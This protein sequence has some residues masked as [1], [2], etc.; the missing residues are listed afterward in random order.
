[1]HA[2]PFRKLPYSPIQG[3][4]RSD[5]EVPR[6]RARAPRSGPL[7]V[8]AGGYSE[9]SG[10][11][12]VHA[13]DGTTLAPLFRASRCFLSVSCIER[14]GPEA[15]VE[16]LAARVASAAAISWLMVPP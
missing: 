7:R 6:D 4:G 10:N 2:A 9:S 8:I 13:W 1:M 12:Y 11:V 3:I 16:P 15:I 5:W 14:M